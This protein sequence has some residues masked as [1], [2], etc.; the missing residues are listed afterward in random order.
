MSRIVAVIAGAGV[1]GVAS[2]ILLDLGQ[3]P[4][5]PTCAA[6][7]AGPAAIALA[8][9]RPAPPGVAYSPALAAAQRHSVRHASVTGAQVM[10]VQQ[11]GEVASAQV[12]VSGA[13]PYGTYAVAEN[14]SFVCSG[15]KWV[16]DG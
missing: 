10:N 6:P 4:T 1:L 3:A 14:L 2:G 9:G 13:S 15:R 12:L 7:P 11:A 16:L 8:A 5:S